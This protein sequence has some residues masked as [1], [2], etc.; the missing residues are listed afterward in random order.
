[1]RAKRV[2]P[3]L[4]LVLAAAVVLAIWL[5]RFRP[6]TPAERAA[7]LTALRAYEQDRAGAA[8][9]EQAEVVVWGRRARATYTRCHSMAQQPFEPVR[10]ELTNREGVWEVVSERSDRPWW[11]PR[12]K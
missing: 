3:I 6:A 10:V 12:W 7:I 1:M 5:W 4:A 2:I 8:G 11:Q 9:L